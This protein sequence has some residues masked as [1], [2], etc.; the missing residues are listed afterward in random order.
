MENE[1][2]FCSKCNNKYKVHIGRFSTF[3]SCNFCLEIIKRPFNHED[4]CIKPNIITVKKSYETGLVYAYLQCK[5]C[6]LK[7]DGP[8]S[9]KG[10]D[11]ENTPYFYEKLNDEITKLIHLENEEQFTSIQSLK[12]NLF[13]EEYSEYL[14]SEVWKKKRNLVLTRDNFLCQACLTNKASE[15]HHKTYKHVYN[16]PLFE[17][18]SICKPCHEKITEL[19]REKKRYI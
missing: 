1:L 15:V 7:I 18:V 12:K 11:L 9:K 17:L 4:W 19:D 3:F 14:L 8:I 5:T 6:G 13:F 2:V 16:E 10:L